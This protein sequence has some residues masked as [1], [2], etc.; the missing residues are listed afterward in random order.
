M[1]LMVSVDSTYEN[2]TKVED[3]P[4]GKV[5]SFERQLGR[6]VRSGS[7][8]PN[9]GLNG[10]TGLN[11]RSE[12]DSVINQ[13][14]RIVFSNNC[15]NGSSNETECTQSVEDDASKACGL[16]YPWVYEN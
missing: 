4:G 11:G 15:H 1:G 3:L 2:R 13:R 6:V 12:P 9:G 8:L 16:T 10:V 14:V 5:L 7:N